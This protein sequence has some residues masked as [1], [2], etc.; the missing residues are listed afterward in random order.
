MIIKIFFV[1]LSGEGGEER[2]A[3]PPCRNFLLSLFAVF[4]IEQI[5]MFCVCDC[6]MVNN[7]YLM[8]LLSEK[9]SV[10]LVSYESDV[11]FD[12]I[13]IVW[14]S[15]FDLFL[16]GNQFDTLELVVC[17]WYFNTRVGGEIEV[18]KN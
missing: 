12:W 13:E 10:K 15:L 6:Q 11:D 4:K 8:F 7:I 17:E 9:Y 18:L 3:D 14:K 2:Q 5:S 16:N 1:S